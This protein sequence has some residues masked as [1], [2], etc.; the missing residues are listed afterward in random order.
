MKI[1]GHSDVYGGMLVSPS[2][3]ASAAASGGHYNYGATSCS[4]HGSVW[5]D[6]AWCDSSVR[7]SGGS[8][9]VAMVGTLPGDKVLKGVATWVKWSRSGNT[10]TQQYILCCDDTTASYGNAK[11]SSC[12]DYD[13]SAPIGNWQDWV[14]NGAAGDWQNTVDG[15]KVVIAL[16]ESGGHDCD[17]SA[18]QKAPSGTQSA[19]CHPVCRFSGSFEIKSIVE[20]CV[21]ELQPNPQCALELAPQT[22]TRH[23]GFSCSNSAGGSP[24]FCDGYTSNLE[25]AATC[26]QACSG[27]DACGGYETAVDGSCMLLGQAITVC[28]YAKE[29]TA[30]EGGVFAGAGGSV[31]ANAGELTTSVTRVCYLKN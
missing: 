22:Y 28:P 26:E 20:S 12:L 7:Y 25:G 1:N 15:D 18:C 17:W 30:D 27:M 13:A 21:N 9:D 24:R 31:A 23:E 4:Y 10:L 6:A 2:V 8:M 29:A 11:C 14:G 3:D 16:G 19:P 5:K